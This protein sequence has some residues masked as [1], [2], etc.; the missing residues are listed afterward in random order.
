[1]G[2]LDKVKNLAKGR[3]KDIAKGVDTVSKFAKEKAPDKYD[4]KIDSATVQAKKAVQK[5]PD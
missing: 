4:S 2:F 5:L 1:M 3:K